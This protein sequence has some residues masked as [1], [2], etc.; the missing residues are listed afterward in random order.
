MSK[1]CFSFP[2]DVSP[3]IRIRGTAHYGAYACFSYQAD[4]PLRMP[5]SCYSYPGDVAQGGNPVAARPAVPGLRRMP[6]SCFS[7]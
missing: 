6:E 3:G 1:L 5:L 2:A 7:Y 4:M